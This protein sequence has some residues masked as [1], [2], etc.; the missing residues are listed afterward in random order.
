MTCTI[1]AAPHLRLTAADAEALRRDL[2]AYHALY[3]PLFQRRELKAQS[4]L[5]L[6]G[7]LSAE[8]RKSV[9]RMVLQQRGADSNAVRTVLLFVSQRRWPDGPLLQRHWEEVARSLGPA[10]GVL[11]VD[12]RDFRK[13]GRESVGVARQDCGGLGQRA[14]CLAGVFLAYASGAG[15]TLIHRQ[16][17]LSR[18]WVED[19]AWV[20]RRRCG[21]PERIPFQTKP[22]IAATLVAEVMAAGSWPVRWVTCDEG[23]GCD[24]VFLDRLAALGLGH[25]A[26]APH[27]TR[28]WPTRPQMCVP[29]SPVTGRPSHP[30]AAGPRRAP[31]AGG[32]GGGRPG[33][34]RAQPGPDVW[35][36]LRRHPQTK[37]LKTY[38]IHGPPEMTLAQLVWLAAM[39]WPI[40]TC[41][42]AGKQ[43]LGLG[44]YEG[45]SWIGWHHHMTLCLLA[46][47]FLVRQ[48]VRRT[49]KPPP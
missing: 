38:L 36:R 10:E 30:S 29:H 1:E 41:L 27:S 13:Q 22:Q 34:R 49:K 12:G 47:F 19:A 20:P 43:L 16:L 3:A 8:R 28:V 17:Y 18:H 9:E 37:Q 35:L 44:D 7:L 11:I 46:H 23:Y 26:E 5:Y 14:N 31:R 45:R 21:V 2:A 48:K 6:E 33:A 40:E 4:L 42:Q 39:R 15:A 32:P 25:C 24:A